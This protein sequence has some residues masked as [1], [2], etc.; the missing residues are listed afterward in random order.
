MIGATGLIGRG[1]ARQLRAASSVEFHAL[2][3]RETGRK[4]EVMIDFDRLPELPD[5]LTAC[6]IAICCLGSTIRKAGNW[7]A[8]ARIDTDY[9]ANFAAAARKAGARQ[10]IHVSSV[11]AKVDAASRYLRM[12]GRTEAKLSALG[13][14]RL[15][16]VR[17]GLLLGA[18][19]EFRLAEKVGTI[20]APVVNPFL[21]GKAAR[22]QGIAADHVAGAIAALMEKDRPGRFVHFNPEIDRLAKMS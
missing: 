14:H 10:F 16:I 19:S 15:D 4:G 20:L 9:V 11:G 5:R 13:F 6:D 2:V 12:K 3:R 17:P 8:F 7:E 22:Y 21:R 18:R 1:V